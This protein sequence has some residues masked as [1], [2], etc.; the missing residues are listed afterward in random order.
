MCFCK[1]PQSENTEDTSKYNTNISRY[2]VR[3]NVFRNHRQCVQYLA[4]EEAHTSLGQAELLVVDEA[5]AIPLP[6]VKGMLGKLPCVMMMRVS[7][8]L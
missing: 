3:I 5:A 2:V 1:I 8:V 6:I 4:P 7:C